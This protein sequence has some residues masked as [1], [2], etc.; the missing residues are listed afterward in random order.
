MPS[1]VCTGTFLHVMF[2]MQSQRLYYDNNSGTYYS[3]DVATGTFEVHHTI[4]LSAV[5][6]GEGSVETG[7]AAHTRADGQK[8]ESDDESLQDLTGSNIMYYFEVV[9]VRNQTWF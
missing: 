6:A 7:S 4:N 8:L 9:F 3:R 2:L 1:R 5:V